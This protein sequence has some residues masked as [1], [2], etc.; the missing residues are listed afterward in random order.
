MPLYLVYAGPDL[1]SYMCRLDVI[2][3]FDDPA[4]AA[5]WSAMIGPASSERDD[6]HNAK[7]NGGV[8]IVL[9]GTLEIGVSAGDLRHVAAGPGDAFVIIDTIGKGHWAKLSGTQPFEAINIRL[10][11]DTEA[12]RR[13][14][15]NWP[16]D[17]LLPGQAANPAPEARKA[18]RR[19]AD[20][21]CGKSI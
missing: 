4:S 17:A 20:M 12:L 13:G 21:G 11:D 15:R 16:D 8:Q 14:F 7:V 1:E 5:S 19:S 3:N 2:S 18:L 9:R 6:W 10:T